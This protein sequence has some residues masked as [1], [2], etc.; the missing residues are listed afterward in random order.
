MVRV[1][2]GADEPGEAGGGDRPGHAELALRPGRGGVGEIATRDQ[3][4][5][6]IPATGAVAPVP[7][8]RPM[9]LPETV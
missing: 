2:Q 5:D 8:Q 3:R 6:R 9:S 1:V 7:G 4:V